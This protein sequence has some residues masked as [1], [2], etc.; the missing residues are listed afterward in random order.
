MKLITFD[1]IYITIY[2]IIQ[3]SWVAIF[4]LLILSC[5]EGTVMADGVLFENSRILI[6]IRLANSYV[7]AIRE[8]WWRLPSTSMPVSLRLSQ[9]SRLYAT[10]GT[11][12]NAGDARTRVLSGA[13]NEVLFGNSKRERERE[14]CVRG[15]EQQWPCEATG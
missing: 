12:W 6:G 9:F 8:Q 3:V 14:R 4:V 1:L 10:E 11:I 13:K 2:K 5:H 15:F 7:Y